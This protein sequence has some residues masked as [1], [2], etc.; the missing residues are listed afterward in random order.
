MSRLVGSDKVNFSQAHLNKQLIRFIELDRGERLPASERRVI[1]YGCCHGYSIVYSYMR[2]VGKSKWWFD[3]LAK[4]SAWYGDRD[5]LKLH[6][7]LM[8]AERGAYPTL[9]QLFRRMVDYVLSAQLGNGDTAHFVDATE[10]LAYLQPS[11]DKFACVTQTIKYQYYQEPCCWT[12][13]DLDAFLQIGAFSQCAVYVMTSRNHAVSVCFDTDEQQWFL[14]DCNDKDY[15]RMFP[16]SQQLRAHIFLTYGNRVAFQVATWRDSAVIE[17]QQLEVPARSDAQLMRWLDRA[18]SYELVDAWVGKPEIRRFL[19]RRLRQNDIEIAEFILRSD[20]SGAMALQARFGVSSVY[21]SLWNIAF[22]HFRVEGG[23]DLQPWLERISA[24]SL[25]LLCVKDKPR[26]DELVCL[27][28]EKIA[29]NKAITRA[30]DDLICLV[31]S[32]VQSG[33]VSANHIALMQALCADS[34][35]NVLMQRVTSKFRLLLKNDFRR[36]IALWKALACDD[37]ALLII[38]YLLKKDAIDLIKLK[39]D[40]EFDDDSYVREFLSQLASGFETTNDLMASAKHWC[41][42]YLNELTVMRI[43]QEH[44]I[45]M[46]LGSDHWFVCEL[47]FVVDFGDTEQSIQALQH[48]VAKK[49][50]VFVKHM[51]EKVVQISDPGWGHTLML[52]RIDSLMLRMVDGEIYR[53]GLDDIIKAMLEHAPLECMTWFC[54]MS[55]G[56]YSA[57]A[58]DPRIQKLVY[59]NYNK[60][61]QLLDV[62]V[63]EVKLF[64]SRADMLSLLSLDQLLDFSGGL[65]SGISGHY[66]PFHLRGMSNSWRMQLLGNIKSELLVRVTQGKINKDDGDL[67]RVLGFQRSRF[68]RLFFKKTHSLDCLAS[69]AELS[70]DSLMDQVPTVM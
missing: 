15:V 11:Q 49:P 10:Q 62:V 63:H 61:A 20:C 18:R 53:V 59:V 33:F 26:F 42:P 24:N 57:R 8:D 17:L 7:R 50:G 14:Y 65:M 34:T 31:E 30:V 68:G 47:L 16:T 19:Q 12:A 66:A 70:S 51:F 37:S 40:F 45:S 32:G 2:A 44:N 25:A 21:E 56:T 22:L 43:M 69:N 36:V 46:A 55:K 1:E 54:D 3:A 67:I 41:S 13:H 29:L 60:V 48:L 9:Q 64:L 23:S 6:V 4:L 38:R 39:Y 28:S 58:Y 35:P 52:R 5:S 27:A